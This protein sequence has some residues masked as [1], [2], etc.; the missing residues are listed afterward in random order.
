MINETMV[1]TNV[2]LNGYKIVES[3]GIVRGRTV[4][5]RSIAGNLAGGVQSLFGGKLSIYVQLCEK[6]EVLPYGTS[7]RAEKIL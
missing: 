4:R 1:T 6:A 5:S 7:V 3:L 2:E